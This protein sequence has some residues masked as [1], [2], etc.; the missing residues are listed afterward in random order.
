MKFDYLVNSPH[1]LRLRTL[2]VSER[3]LGDAAFHSFRGAAEYNPLV[4]SGLKRL[5]VRGCGVSWSGVIS[6]ESFEPW[7]FDP[8]ELD[9]GNN[10][11]DEY[12]LILLTQ[13]FGDALKT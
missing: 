2:D 7:Q 11:L 3:R 5:R 6:I 10:D 8:E 9:V 13:R 12:S 1:F 4:L